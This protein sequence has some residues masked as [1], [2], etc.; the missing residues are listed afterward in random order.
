MKSD[1]L[2]QMGSGEHVSSQQVTRLLAA[3]SN[4]DKAALEALTP[5]VYD[6]L[7]RLARIYMRRERVGHTLQSTAVVHEAYIR[8]VDQDVKWSGKSHFLAIAA[9][10]MRRIL[11]DHARARSA[12]KRGSGIAPIPLEDDM[13]ASEK[14]ADELLALDEA[15]QQLAKVDALRAQIVELRFFGGLS[16]EETASILG[17]PSATVQRQW[18]G[19]KAWLY[20]AMRQ[21]TRQ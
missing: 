13:V 17:I 20:S 9:Q 21:E 15:L 6:E 4:G 12:G 16:K 7:R 19:A 14:Q 11:V 2:S 1:E 10:M 18:A 3:W 8:L 5:L